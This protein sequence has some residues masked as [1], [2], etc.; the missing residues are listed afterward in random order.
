MEIAVLILGSIV[1]VLIIVLSLR[2]KKIKKLENVVVQ[3]NTDIFQLNKKL[4]IYQPIMDIEKEVDKLIIEKKSLEEDLRSLIDYYSDYEIKTDLVEMSYYQPKY[5]FGYYQDYADALIIIREAQKEVIKNKNV[6]VQEPNS[7]NKDIANLAVSAFSS[8]ST[9]LINKVT[10]TNY[11]KSKEKLLVAFNKVN[12]LLT[13]F[14]LTVSKDFLELKYQEMGLVYD[15]KEQEKR[16]KDEQQELKEQMKEEEKARREAEKIREKALAEQERYEKALEAAREEIASKTGKERDT[17]E[18]K[19]LQLEEKLKEA[20]EEKERATA[21]AQ[22]TK[23]GHVYIISN[24]GSF[25]ENVFKIG[26]TRRTEPMDRVKELGDAS[27][28]FSFDVHAMVYA[29]NAPELEN[30]LHKHFEDKRMNRINLRKEF[31]KIGI[32]EI[33]KACTEHGYKIKLSRLAEAMEYRQSID[34]ERANN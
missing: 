5:D 28:P 9:E 21:M 30:T 32:D 11:E 31:F 25:G 20:L 12:N 23:K 34:L 24:I 16:I 27:V 1:V 2:G 22:I 14:G 8:D 13:T 10:Y 29:E 4:S 6:F 15:F 26:M 18:K 19:I 3:N 7:Q 17:Y 33:E